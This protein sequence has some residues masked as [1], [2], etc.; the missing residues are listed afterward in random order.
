MD[1]APG[2]AQIPTN[3]YGR[4]HELY[5]RGAAS[6]VARRLPIADSP[7]GPPRTPRPAP[8]QAPLRTP[9][10]RQQRRGVCRPPASLG[11]ERAA[12]A[13]ERGA[14]PGRAGGAAAAAG[15]PLAREVAAEGQGKRNRGRAARPPP[16][17]RRAPGLG[18]ALVAVTP[19]VSGRAQL[20]EN[21][22]QQSPPAGP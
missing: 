2:E 3:R 6:S 9:A 13:A 17:R 11:H 4:G 14:G 8:R 1:M 10:A 15:S 19:S 7:A 18:T 21:P 20:R 22:A 5:G 16:R 12:A